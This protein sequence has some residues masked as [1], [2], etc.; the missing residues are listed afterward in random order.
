[1]MRR[2]RDVTACTRIYITTHNNTKEGSTQEY[3][4]I[5]QLA[6][7]MFH[8]LDGKM[9]NITVLPARQFSQSTARQRNDT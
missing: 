9:A 4:T 7:K 5:H 8:Y 6:S 3:K 1:M 2:S